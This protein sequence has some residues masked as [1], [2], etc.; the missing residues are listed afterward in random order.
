MDISCSET[1]DKRP[2]EI[3]RTPWLPSKENQ[4]ETAV[5]TAVVEI[6]KI[7]ALQRCF[8]PRILVLASQAV[9]TIIE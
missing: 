9:F 5:M 8:V 3:R 7:R 4:S 6:S 2:E 1:S